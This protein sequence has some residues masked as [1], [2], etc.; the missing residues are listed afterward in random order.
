MSEECEVQTMNTSAD[1]AMG[2]A[3]GFNDACKPAQPAPVPKPV[4]VAWMEPCGTLM[5]IS[6]VPNPER[7]TDTAVPLYTHPAAPVP[8]PVPLTDEQIDAIPFRALD[9]GA[10]ASFREFAHA[11]VAKFCEVNGIAASPEKP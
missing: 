9:I 2:Y 6:E 7:P 3:E 1:Y 10:I 5:Y 8:V 4:P 11:A